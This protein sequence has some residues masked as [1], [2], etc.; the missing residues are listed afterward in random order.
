[1]DPPNK[2]ILLKYTS[3]H[4][5]NYKEGENRFD[6]D[7]FSLEILNTKRKDQR[8]YEYVVSRDAKEKV[9]QIQL[10]VYEPVSDPSIQVLNWMLANS[11]CTVTL[12]CTAA[13]GDNVSYSW[14]SPEAGT[15][16]PCTHN[17]SLLQLS[18]DPNNSSL[19]CACTASNP[20]SRRTVTFHPSAC[21]FQ[22]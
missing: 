10:E 1:E 20:V 16:A 18:Y 9:W 4:W 5:V 21:S 19:A 12:N 7:S 14:A 15:S 13:R 22:Q 6:P 2:D 11:S 3:G 8:L 17:G